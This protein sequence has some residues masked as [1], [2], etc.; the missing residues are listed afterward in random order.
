LATVACALVVEARGICREG[1]ARPCEEK[2]L[3]TFG[4]GIHSRKVASDC[5]ET[6]GTPLELVVR[7]DR[8]GRSDL[9][10]SRYLR[11]GTNRLLELRIR[12]GYELG[13]V[14]RV[15]AACNGVI[16]EEQALTPDQTVLS[17]PHSAP[18][19]TD[20]EA[21]EQESIQRLKLAPMQPA[22]RVRE[23][24]ERY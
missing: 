7:T 6:I 8:E 16:S 13:Y 14:D 10:L 21:A 9:K 22:C 12:D 20:V 24:V 19:G 17:E 4:I 15:H 11:Y 2:S 1:T 23:F 18:Y 3:G 5:G